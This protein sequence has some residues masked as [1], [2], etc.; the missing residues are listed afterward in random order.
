MKTI[1]LTDNP[2]L[3]L[4]YTADEAEKELSAIEGHGKRIKNEKGDEAI[5]GWCVSCIRKHLGHIEVLADECGGGRCLV[6]PVWDEMKEWA[7]S[8]R[9]KLTRVI[10]EGELITQDEAKEINIKATYFRKE[11]EKM[12]LGIS[13]EEEEEKYLT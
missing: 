2:E 9:G 4:E 11:M 1:D 10:K 12:V 5:I 8:N 6:Q 7:K 3:F 13:S